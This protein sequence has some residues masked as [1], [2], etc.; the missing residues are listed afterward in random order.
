MR[1]YIVEHGGKYFDGTGFNASPN[2][3]ML[4]NIYE[5]EN[6]AQDYEE[7]RGRYESTAYKVVSVNI[8]LEEEL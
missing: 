6:V 2:M 5:A 3:A 7:N 4:M 1:A 8:T